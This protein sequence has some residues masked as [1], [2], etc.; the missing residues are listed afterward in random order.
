MRTHPAWMIA[1]VC[2]ALSPQLGIAQ[3]EQRPVYRAGVASVFVNVSVKEGNVPIAGLAEEDFAVFDNG[4]R[5]KIDTL[6]FEPVPIDLTLFQDTSNSQAGRIE[7]LKEDVRNIAALL[8]PGDRIRLLTL[9]FQVKDVFGW[10]PAG[11]RLDLSA[12]RLGHNS[13]VYDPIFA[14]MMHQPDPDRRHL[15]VAL[16]DGVDGGS[17]VG[18]QAVLDAARHSEGVLHL[19]LLQRSRGSGRVAGYWMPTHADRDGLRRLKEAA[20]LTGGRVYT[21]IFR[22]NVI[23]NFRQAFD[24]FRQSYVLRYTPS[25][26]PANG[27]H[28]IKVELPAYPRAMIRARKGYFGAA[29]G[30]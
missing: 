12:V 1:S 8:R 13:A 17:A 16:T 19:V 18:S 3:Q 26:V 22:A 14:A 2:L 28:D 21:Q 7:S 6:G 4:V 15:I 30:F 24:E 23:S 25:G 11:T 9:D 27:W 10:Q 5:Q 20:E 29:S